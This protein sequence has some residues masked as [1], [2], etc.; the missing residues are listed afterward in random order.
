MKTFIILGLGLLI[1]TLTTISAKAQ[2]TFDL[3]EPTGEVT[4][5]AKIESGQILVR[6]LAGQ[7]ASFSR[8]PS[9]DSLG[10]EFIG[11]YSPK[12]NRALRF[13][14]SGSGV[15]QTAG[16]GDPRPRFINTR[17]TVRLR[18]GQVVPPWTFGAPI[19]FPGQLFP[20]HPGHLFPGHPGHVAH[21]LQP[22]QWY[23]LPFDP[24]VRGYT[25]WWRRPQAILVDAVVVPDPP[26]PPARLKLVNDGR[27]EVQ[28]EVR[29]L[30]NSTRTRQ[31]RIQPRSS[32]DIELIRDTGGKR[33]EQFRVMT[34][35]GYAGSREIV[36][37]YEPAVRYEL[38]VHEWAMQS[39]A[40][41]RTGKSPNVIEDI[42]FQ[43]R[44]IG[45]FFLPPG[46]LLQSGVIG[47]HSAAE[48]QKNSG[49]VPPLI[50]P[51]DLP[52][53]GGRTLEDAVLEAQRAAQRRASGN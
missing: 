9:L 40:I 49:T 4:A 37:E 13:P 25:A 26:L 33:I 52:K 41:D 19:F 17:R 5:I 8:D 14:R 44:G 28:V 50:P 48:R 23:G 30:Q 12:M 43:G 47:V 53:R 42:N 45:R 15:M 11:Y 29:D 35:Y 1:T 27:R 24:V 21:H 31:M 46:P 39:V 10:G 6:S 38:V 3:V 20:G 34:R 22:W 7:R 16:L 51:E 32:T 18:R 2:Q 36:T